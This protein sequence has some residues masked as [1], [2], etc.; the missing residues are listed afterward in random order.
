MKPETDLPLFLQT[1]PALTRTKDPSSSHRGSLWVQGGG[2][3]GRQEALV[4]KAVRENP[5]LTARELARAI[6]C[7]DV[8]IPARRLAS[9]AERGLVKRGPER[10]CRVTGMTA[11][12]WFPLGTI[13][14]GRPAVSRPERREP[15]SVLTPE[16]RRAMREQLASS[17]SE[18]QRHFLES[19]KSG[20]HGE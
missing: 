17:G 3:L 18:K 20:G 16:Q 13:R 12:T 14:A 2:R 8:N 19:L 10:R 5:G 11:Q 6:D 9:L 1:R 4:L 15:V 7:G